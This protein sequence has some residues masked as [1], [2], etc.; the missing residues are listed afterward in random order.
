MIDRSWI[1]ESVTSARRCRTASA[2]IAV[3]KKKFASVEKPR[4][5]ATWPA[6]SGN[7]AIP[8]S[9]TRNTR[10]DMLPCS[11]IRSRRIRRTSTSRIAA[12]A[13]PK[14]HVPVPSPKR[15]YSSGGCIG[16]LELGAPPARAKYARATA[17]V[18]LSM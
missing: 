16:H 7:S 2:A 14:I 15:Q 11:V 13:A 4:A 3:Q 5:C 18:T 10:N 12:H 17:S 6:V 1:R 9:R 8:P